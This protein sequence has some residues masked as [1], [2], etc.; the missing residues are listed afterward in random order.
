MIRKCSTY[1]LYKQT[2]L[3]SR[4]NP[5]GTQRKEICQMDV[6]NF[7]EFGNLKYVHHTIDTGFQWATALSSE[8][9]DS[10]IT[11]LLEVMAIMGI[12]A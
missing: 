4:S 10:V 9:A 1:S 6:F 11:Y 2:L 3:L 8:K 5:K 7:T 12:P